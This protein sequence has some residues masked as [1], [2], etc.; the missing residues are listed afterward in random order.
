VRG[1]A[2][3]IA[4]TAIWIFA[5][6]ADQ[7]FPLM[8]AHLG[9]SGAFFVFA[10]MAAL[11]FMFVLFFVPETKGYSLEQISHIWLTHTIADANTV[12]T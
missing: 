8:Q 4:T 11:N 10:V 12:K 3:S 7:F 6:L 2:M 1:T 9:S 5:Y